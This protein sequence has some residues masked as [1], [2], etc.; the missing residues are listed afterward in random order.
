MFKQALSTVYFVSLNIKNGTFVFMNKVVRNV[1]KSNQL[2]WYKYHT[3][4]V[5]IHF[6]RLYKM[7]KDRLSACGKNQM[8]I[9]S[10]AFPL[11]HPV[12]EHGG[13]KIHTFWCV[14]N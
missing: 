11:G 7:C 1:Y 8:I 12:W 3:F 14:W 4:K 5:V 6:H 13:A 10:D 9:V 2:L